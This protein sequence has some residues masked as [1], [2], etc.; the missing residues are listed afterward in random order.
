[1]T[2]RAKTSDLSGA[3]ESNLN[4]AEVLWKMRQQ[5]CRQAPTAEEDALRLVL[6]KIAQ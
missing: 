1:M 2:R 3:V 5:E 6:A 4:L